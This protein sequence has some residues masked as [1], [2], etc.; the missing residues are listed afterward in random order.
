MVKTIDTSAPHDDQYAKGRVKLAQGIVLTAPGIPAILQGT[1]WLE[2]NN[3]GTDAG[4][5]IDWSHKTTYAGIF[6]YF[7][8]VIHLRTSNPALR[9]DAGIEIFHVNDGSNVIAFRRTDYGDN[10]VVVVA[11]F[12]NSDFAGYRIG[13]PLFEDWVEFANS[14]DSKYMGSGVSNPGTIAPDAIARDG[15]SQSVEIALAAMALVILTPADGVGVDTPGE[16]AVGLRLYPPSPN[17]MVHGTRIVF[18]LPAPAP[19]R[20]AV[21]DVS[22]RLVQVV[23]EGSYPAGRSEVAWDGR[24]RRGDKV[25]GGIYVI[26]IESGGEEAIGKAIVLR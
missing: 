21:Y 25:A 24:N 14:Q 19:A 20:I 5:R 12:S 17:P 26:R 23:G 4:N 7:R 1:E 22:G 16:P 10:D 6:D 3:F 15:Y 2:D 11:N 18:D 8:D 13:V 9:A